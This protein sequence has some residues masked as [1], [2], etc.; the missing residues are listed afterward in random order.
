MT[1]N[2]QRIRIDRGYSLRQLAQALG[3]TATAVHFWERGKTQ[4][5]PGNAKGLREH[6]GLPLDVLLAESPETETAG[7]EREPAVPAH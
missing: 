6:F 4:P 3:V 1:T 2:L 5:H 7:S